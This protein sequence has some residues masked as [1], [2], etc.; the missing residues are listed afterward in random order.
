MIQRIIT[1]SILILILAT[2]LTLGG[3][4]FSVPFMLFVTASVYEVF[5]AFRISGDDPVSW[6]VY[7]VLAL[8]LPVMTLGIGRTSILLPFIELAVVMIT[9][10]VLFRP[11]PKLMDI[12]VSLLP[13]LAAVLPGLCMLSFLHAGSR[14]LELYFLILSFGAPLMGDTC[15]YFIG[16]IYGKTKLCEAVSPKKTVEGS[17]AGL[18][19][20]VVFAV[21]IYLIFRD[22]LTLPLWHAPFLGLFAGIAGQTGDLFASIIKRHCG[23]KD[24]GSVFPGHG[25]IMDRLDSVYWATI[26]IYIYMNWIS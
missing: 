26:V 1:G 25:G 2:A 3:W 14:A 17:L 9:L 23:I 4:W 22:S 6:P 5:R 21:V 24:F 18:F 8:S 11:K 12:I 10:V 20:S 19:G 7:L 16:V 13:I 15:A